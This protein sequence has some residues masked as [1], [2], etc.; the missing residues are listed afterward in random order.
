MVLAHLRSTTPALPSIFT[1]SRLASNIGPLTTLPILPRSSLMPALA[2]A[3]LSAATVRN[4]S[5]SSR[6]D[7]GV[8]KASSSAPLRDTM[9][10]TASSSA[11]TPASI[12]STLAAASPVISSAAFFSR[13]SMC[14]FF[15]ASSRLAKSFLAATT[16]FFKASKPVW[17]AVTLGLI[18]ASSVLASAS[19]PL[20][21]AFAS[22]VVFVLIRFDISLMLFKDS[23]SALSISAAKVVKGVIASKYAVPWFP[24]MVTKPVFPF[25]TMRHSNRVMPV[26]SSFMG[27]PRASTTAFGST[28]PFVLLLAISKTSVRLMPCLQMNCRLKA[29][30]KSSKPTKPS[31]SASMCLKIATRRGSV[32]VISSCSVVA[33]RPSRWATKRS[34]LTLPSAAPRLM[35]VKKASS[36]NAFFAM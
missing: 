14:A 26:A 35:S 25:E 16:F 18:F 7:A 4:R 22:S 30:L 36:V 34:W 5:A 15:S 10:C 28:F 32:K 24:S 6:T 13:A 1:S 2:A 27:F 12:A 29:C 17:A 8:G 9:G 31:L 21:P 3:A 19:G 11:L 33:G 20:F 23:A